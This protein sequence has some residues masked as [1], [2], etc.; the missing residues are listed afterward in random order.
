MLFRY[1]CS[2]SLV[3]WCSGK[4]LLIFCKVTEVKVGIGNIRTFT[5]QETYTSRTTRVASRKQPLPALLLQR[6]FIGRSP[7]E[8]YHGLLINKGFKFKI[9]SFVEHIFLTWRN[10]R[11]NYS[12]EN[13]VKFFEIA[14]SGKSAPFGFIQSFWFSLDSIGRS[15][16]TNR[17]NHTWL[18]GSVGGIKQKKSS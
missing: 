1:L 8:I 14:I 6:H 5:N 7:F 10:F 4:C 2:I 18:Q 17:P 11:K 12:F 9:T 13:H 3:S 16:F 15:N